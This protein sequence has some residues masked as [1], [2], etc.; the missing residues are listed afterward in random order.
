MRRVYGKEIRNHQ[1]TLIYLNRSYDL[2]LFGIFRCSLLVDKVDL[3]GA[4][5]R[6]DGARVREG[7]VGI[8]TADLGGCLSCLSCLCR[9]LPPILPAC[10][11][12]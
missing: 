8:Y 7:F 10:P 12:L 11:I 9:L 4:R 1:A 6:D 5:R 3:L 2:T